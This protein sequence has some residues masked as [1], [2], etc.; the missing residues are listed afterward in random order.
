MKNHDPC[1]PSGKSADARGDMANPK[2]RIPKDP[3]T[4]PAFIRNCSS[5]VA[6]TLHSST[7]HSELLIPHSSPSSPRALKIFLLS[8]RSL[9]SIPDEK[10]CSLP[11]Q[12]IKAR[13]SGG[14]WGIQKGTPY[15][16][17]QGPR[18]LNLPGKEYNVVVPLF[19]FLAHM[20]IFFPYRRPFNNDS[21]RKERTPC[22][23]S[24]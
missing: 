11:L 18:Y 16:P 7:L 23:S 8:R 19:L 13:M 22:R 17:G 20:K 12:R 21:R 5:P 24:V 14:I 10:P 3:P 1:R 2:G 9:T 15:P 6:N 4:G